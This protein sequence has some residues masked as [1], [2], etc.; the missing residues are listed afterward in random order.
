LKK[1]L[2]AVCLICVLKIS[3]Y[4]GVIYYDD[5]ISVGIGGRPTAMGKA[6]VALS[7][8]ANA[9]FLN[10][11]GL[12]TQKSWKVS[13]MNSNFL[14][15][16]QYTMFCG[17]DPTPYGTLGMGYV[18][19]RIGD[20]LLTDDSGT[21]IGTADFYNQAL[22]LSYGKYI[23][24]II[25]DR[26]PFINLKDEPDLYGGVTLKYYSK[27]YTG[28]VNATGSGYN[29]DLGLKY[30]QE[31]WLSYGLNFQNVLSGSKISGDFEQEDM[32]FLTKVGVLF[33]W[34]EH[35]VNIEVD[36]D[37]FLG[38]DNVPWPTHFGVEWNLHPNLS[39]RAGA[40]Q[41]ANSAN[42]GNLVDNTTFGLGLDYNGI[43]VDLAYVQN[44]G[45]LNMAS[46]VISLT[47]YSQPTF[48][49]KEVAAPAPVKVDKLTFT[50][51]TDL[52]T[53]DHE[54]YFQGTVAPDVT[55][56]WLAGKKL[57]IKNGAFEGS[58]ALELGR[59]EKAVK[60]RDASSTEAE[61][62]RKIIRFYVPQ[63][64]SQDEARSKSFEYLVACSEIR[65][66][67]GKDYS[68]K[69]PLTRAAVAHII[70]KA[71]KLDTS[72]TPAR[73]FKDVKR[74]NP[75]A[76]YIEAVKYAGIMGGYT[77]GTF[78]PENNLTLGEL[79]QAMTK[80]TPNLDQTA[81]L[82]YVATRP[83]KDNAAMGDV[84]EMM[85]HFGKPGMLASEISDYKAYIGAGNP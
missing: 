62:T 6:F 68:L 39:L 54:Q 78:K 80:A 58:V 59:N 36:K 22:V 34:L 67:L 61:V 17:V 4:A 5:P 37:M 40:N 84:V 49:V 38:R 2:A 31:D 83:P 71:K 45:Q 24:D 16:Y 13:T 75:D 57:M 28:D 8:D 10:P 9:M 64:I 76:A 44:Y 43:K 35:D 3:G 12:G 48:I 52:A 1:V 21:P 85:V 69:K 66:Y 74:P 82:R 72:I 55:D 14:N 65:N 46:N 56:V 77:D 63:D 60:I 15:E 79:A 50:P 51:A 81:L 53:I 47:L 41:S 23:G 7:D 29:L 26:I 73:V 42:S 27:G 19:S 25:K 33:R 30:E 18:S 20:I 70:A 32:P 11:A